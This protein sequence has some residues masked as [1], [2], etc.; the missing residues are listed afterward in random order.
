MAVKAYGTT[1]RDPDTWAASTAYPISHFRIPST[2]NGKCYE[3][4]QMGT[5]GSGEPEWPTDLG[6]TVIDG[7]Q[8]Q[9]P[10]LTWTCR[11]L[12][13]NPLEVTLITG[14]LGGCSLKDI[15]VRSVNEEE[16]E[17][18]VY[19]SIDGVNWRQIDEISTPQGDRDNRHKGLQNSYP[20]TKV[21]VE[22]DVLC[23]IEIVAG[24]A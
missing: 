4:T 16:V 18:I 20:Y 7:D 6:Q 10:Y 15:W 1:V 3:V 5:S 8:E 9:G 11:S 19:G 17:F 14:A 23:E 12:G 13:I 24:P 2:P 22:S 21:T